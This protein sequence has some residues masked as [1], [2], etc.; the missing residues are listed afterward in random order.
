MAVNK[1]SQLRTSSVRMNGVH[2]TASSKEFMQLDD[3]HV[4]AARNSQRAL[5]FGPPGGAPAGDIVLALQ[6]N[7]WLYAITS[8]NFRPSPFPRVPSRRHLYDLLQSARKCGVIEDFGPSLSL[9]AAE[10]PLGIDDRVNSQLVQSVLRHHAAV[11]TILHA[12][13]IRRR[14]RPL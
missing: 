8:I 7:H 4:N 5:D 12:C 3:E 14:R 9:D 10:D 2:R 11:R 13:T 1:A 6:A